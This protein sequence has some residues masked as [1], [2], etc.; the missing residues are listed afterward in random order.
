M[1]IRMKTILA[2]PSFTTVPG[3][4]IDVP[5]E[6][7]QALCDGRFAEAV[8]TDPTVAP[9]PESEP[10]TE[11]A[12]ASEEDEYRASLWEK[13]VKTLRAMVEEADVDVGGRVPKAEL[14]DILV[15]H[16][17]PDE[18]ESEG[19]QEPE[20]Q[21]RQAEGREAAA[22]PS[23][24]E[25]ETAEVGPGEAATTRT[26]KPQPRRRRRPRA[27]GRPADRSEGG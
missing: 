17:S 4:V 9:A 2:G 23:P 15:A 27:E 6:Q 11:A 18:S 16:R 22:T 5:D 8:E 10:E 1:R 21:P 14:I 12:P 7:A 3:Q 25:V 13:T 19:S 26:D 20:G 24:D